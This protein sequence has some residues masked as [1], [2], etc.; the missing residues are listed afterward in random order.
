MFQV[1]NLLCIIC[2]YI[3]I[4]IYI[5][6]VLSV[7]QVRGHPLQKHAAPA[8]AAALD[9]QSPAVLSV[10]LCLSGV[11]LSVFHFKK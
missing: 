3:Y 9:A 10:L 1:H 2:I 8:I 4:Y 5:F 6:T 11:P 7:N